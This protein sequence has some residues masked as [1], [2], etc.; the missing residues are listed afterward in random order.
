MSKNQDTEV[1]CIPDQTPKYEGSSRIRNSI[2]SNTICQTSDQSLAFQTVHKDIYA[3][4]TS[5]FYKF[6]A[7]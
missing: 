4:Y 2:H 5:V 6:V 3:V 1:E 7:T